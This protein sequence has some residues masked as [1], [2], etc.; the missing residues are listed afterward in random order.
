MWHGILAQGLTDSFELEYEQAITKATEH[1]RAHTRRLD[2]EPLPTTAL[3]LDPSLAGRMATVEENNE[4]RVSAKSG[5]RI[6]GQDWEQSAQ[7][8]IDEVVPDSRLIESIMGRDEHIDI[9]YG[10]G[11]SKR[12]RARTRVSCPLP[13]PL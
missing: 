1:L 8:K 9:V 4:R 2:N 13:A 6:L 12:C 11:E 10:K 7:R 3:T 5:E